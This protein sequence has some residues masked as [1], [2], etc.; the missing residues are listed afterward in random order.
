MGSTLSAQNQVNTTVNTTLHNSNLAVYSTGSR[1]NSIIWCWCE[2]GWFQLAGSYICAA[3]MA[4]AVDCADG[5]SFAVNIG[6][7]TIKHSF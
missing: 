7:L 4:S 6:V 2:R 3:A 1:P 5:P